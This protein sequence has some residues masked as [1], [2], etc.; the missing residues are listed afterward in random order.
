MARAASLE[1]SGVIARAR[2][3]DGMK[4]ISLNLGPLLSPHRRHGRLSL[5]VERL[6][7]QARFSHGS[8][9]NDG[10]W[11]LATDELDDLSDRILH[12][13]RKRL[14]DDE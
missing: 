12:A 14:S 5:R 11:S 4:V 6:P 10:S 9:N 3:V 2:R 7:Q 13:T 1:A 8:R